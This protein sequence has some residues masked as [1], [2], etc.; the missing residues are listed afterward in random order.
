MGGF[1]WYRIFQDFET[2]IRMICAKENKLTII[3]QSFSMLV[4][5]VLKLFGQISSCFLRWW[6]RWWNSR[7]MIYGWF[8][9]CSQRSR[10]SFWMGCFW[11]IKARI[12]ESKRPGQREREHKSRRF[13]WWEAHSGKMQN[14]VV[15]L[16]KSSECR[17]MLLKSCAYVVC[18]IGSGLLMRERVF[19]RR[20]IDRFSMIFSHISPS[21]LI[22]PTLFTLKSERFHGSEQR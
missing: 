18:C 11:W 10:K 12:H 2:H 14:A 1:R 16:R 5:L 6:M 21:Y 20:L 9:S 19:G 17:W 3:S 15:K 7:K 4:V 13:G 8:L 22:F